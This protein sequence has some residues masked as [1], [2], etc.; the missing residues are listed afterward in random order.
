[1]LALGFVV[2]MMGCEKGWVISVRCKLK[3]LGK[4]WFVLTLLFIVGQLNAAPSGVGSGMVRIPA[5]E[6]IMGSDLQDKDGR[7]TKEYGMGKPLYLDEHPQRRLFLET[8]DIDLTEV[9]NSQY[10]V[11]VIER[12]FWVPEQW[13][14][15]GYLL[16]RR[17]LNI[18]DVET[19]RRLAVEK[20]RLDMDTRAMDKTSLIDAMDKARLALDSL[21]VTSVNWHEAK[22]Y[23]DS[24]GKR[25]PTEMEWEKAARGADG[26]EFPWGDIWDKMRA[27]TGDGLNWEHGVAPVGSYSQGRSPYGVFDMAG[28]VMEWVSDWYQPYPGTEYSADD[29]GEKNKVVRGGGWGGVGHY[30]VSQFYRGAYRFYLTPKARYS[31]L[32]FRCARSV[33]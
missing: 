17:V 20:Y 4:M 16:S 3:L 32:G 9:T 26:N 12:N 28:N 24:V 19:L 18:A 30:A 10:R 7:R 1:M 11:F 2:R 23:C 14:K 15:N 33:R 25:L 21:A 22:A 5:G 6:F 29:F 27:N 31:D 8:F 13:K